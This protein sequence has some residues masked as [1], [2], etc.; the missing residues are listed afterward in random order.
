MKRYTGRKIQRTICGVAA[1]ASFF[2]ALCVVGGIERGL[3]PFKTGI[4]VVIAGVI[5]FGVLSWCAG[6]MRSKR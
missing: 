1:A 6:A 5:C 2:T 4:I 3:A